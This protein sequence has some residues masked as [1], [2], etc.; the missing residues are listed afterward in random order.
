MTGHLRGSK[1][2]LALNAAGG[3]LS[4]SG[5]N[6]DF[7]GN[8]GDLIAFSDIDLQLK[9]SG[10]DLS[11]VGS[12]IGE[13]L[14][15]TDEFTVQG[16]LTGSAKVLSLSEAQG[17]AK[18]GSLSLVLYGGIK[19]LLNFSG[20]DLK[21]KCS[22][23]DL[24]A[25]GA[26]VDEKLPV[27][28]EF[29][30]EGRLTGS[31]ISLALK[32]AHGSAKQGSLTVAIN[33]EVKDLIA[34]S[35]VDLQIKGSGTRFLVQNFN[36]GDLLKETGKSDQVRAT[37]D[38]AAHRK[39]K[40]DSVHSLMANLDGSIGA[41][42]GEGFLTKYLDLLSVGLS[43]KVVHFWKPP[44][45]ADQIKCA[46][47]QF[48]IKQG[49]ATSQ[50]FVFNTRAGILAG[51]GKINLDTEQINFLLVPKPEHPSL[52]LSTKLRVSGTVMDSKVRPDTVSL[53]TKGAELLSTLAIGPLGL[54]APFV[55]LGALNAHPCNI[56]SIGQLGLQSTQ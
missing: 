11:M 47:V 55:H 16:R 12:I 18:R 14:P 45:A 24:S 53:L 37:L 50:A 21:M 34:L 13:K 31:A 29:A 36:L 52:S 9:G 32:E 43:E 22:G 6:L 5:I 38:I 35:G 2:S 4:A 27:T 17:S 56:K 28:E 8:L 49:I 23:K 41:V 7:R 10:E 30:V 15:T 44:K 25:V 33:G 20:V 26:I 42:M 51:T 48:D 1:E 54:L 39:S 19:D 46:V 40:G 3:N